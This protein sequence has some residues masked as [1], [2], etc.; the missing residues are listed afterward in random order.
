MVPATRRQTFKAVGWRLLQAVAGILAG[1]VGLSV[2]LVLMLSKLA[3][4]TSMMMLAAASGLPVPVRYEW[5]AWNDISP[6]LKLAVIAAEDQRFPAHHGFDLIEIRQALAVFADGGTL[7]GASTISQQTAKNLFL[8]RQRSWLRKGLEVWFTVLIET[9][10][11]KQRILEVYLNV[12][13][14]DTGVFGI[15]AGAEH[16]LAIT[17]ARLDR[18]QASLMAALL[19][20]PEGRSASRPSP[21][22]V[23]RSAW[24][25]QQMKALGGLAYLSRLKADKA[26]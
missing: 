2:I 14:W 26:P 19:P 15:K 7:R 5:V 9:F 20:D 21:Q 1:G 12:A 24:I 3:P 11:S 25:R 4:P 6:H 10:W 22:T 18:H 8:W 17:P 13:Q 16:Y 23:R